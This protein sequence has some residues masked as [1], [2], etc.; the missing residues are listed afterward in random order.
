MFKYKY[1]ISF[2]IQL[3]FPRIHSTCV[4]R[5]GRRFF[6]SFFF[7]EEVPADGEDPSSCEAVPE[8]EKGEELFFPVVEEPNYRDMAREEWY[9]PGMTPPPTPTPPPPEYSRWG[10]VSTCASFQCGVVFQCFNVDSCRV[11]M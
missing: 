9:P 6:F 10:V 3:C 7:Y 8:K 1:T 2:I 11:L 5:R 4:Q